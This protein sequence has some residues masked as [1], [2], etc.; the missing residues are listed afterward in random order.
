M[1]K[2]DEQSAGKKHIS[3]KEGNPPNEEQAITLFQKSKEA[4]LAQTKLTLAKRRQQQNN[5]RKQ[6]LVHMDLTTFH[7]SKTIEFVNLAADSS[8]ASTARI[9]TTSSPK[10]FMN[11]SPRSKKHNDNVVNKIKATNKAQEEKTPGANDPDSDTDYANIITIRKADPQQTKPQ[12]NNPTQQDLTTLQPQRS[13]TPIHQDHAQQQQPV[14]HE[15]TSGIEN[16]PQ[17]DTNTASKHNEQPQ[18]NIHTNSN[19]TT[20]TSEQR[21]ISSLNTEDMEEIDKLIFD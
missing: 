21:P 20:K 17:L 9:V 3:T 15:S 5:Q 19:T 16:E 6:L 14:G 8:A 7:N 1:S 12:D 18:R 13:S 10:D 2:N 4:A 11:K